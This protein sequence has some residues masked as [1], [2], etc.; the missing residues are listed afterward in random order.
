MLI[1]VISLQLKKLETSSTLSFDLIEKSKLRLKKVIFF[2][3]FDPNIRKSDF[4][5]FIV[6]DSKKYNYRQCH[7]SFDKKMDF[8]CYNQILA[9]FQ[10]LAILGIFRDFF[11][12]S[13][14]GVKNRHA[15]KKSC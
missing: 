13:F 5:I 12:N 2:M 4:F 11:E 14:L 10:K 15:Y 7:M 3:S 8:S 6:F 1:M 9:Y